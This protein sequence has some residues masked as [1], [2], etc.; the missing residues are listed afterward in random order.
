MKRLLISLIAV[1]AFPAAAN[2]ETVWLVLRYSTGLKQSG[3]GAALEK[4]PMN[5][6][7]NCEMMGAQWMGSRPSRGEKGPVF[8][9]NCLKGK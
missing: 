5:S 6:L 1:I 2:A 9:F 3:V 8:G 4:I 7:Q